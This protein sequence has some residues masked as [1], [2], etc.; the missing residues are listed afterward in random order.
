MP[1]DQGKKM[2][3]DQG[4]KMPMD[5]G[6]KM[7]VDQ[8]KKMSMDQGKKMPVDQGKKMP[9]EHGKKTQQ[10]LQIEKIRSQDKE[11]TIVE[12]LEKLDELNRLTFPGQYDEAVSEF[13]KRWQKLV[14]EYGYQHMMTVEFFKTDHPYPEP[15]FPIK[16]MDDE[17]YMTQHYLSVAAWNRRHKRSPDFHVLEL[18]E[19]K[20]IGAVN[21]S[22]PFDEYPLFQALV[23]I[24]IYTRTLSVLRLINCSLKKEGVV[25]LGKNLPRSSVTHL[26]LDRNPIADEDYS[27]ILKNNTMWNS[28]L[29]FVSLAGNLIGDQG[30]DYLSK[31]LYPRELSQKEINLMNCRYIE[32]IKEL[33]D[34]VNEELHLP[35]VE[36]PN[37]EVD[38]FEEDEEE[39][40]QNLFDEETPKNDIDPIR[41]RVLQQTCDEFLEMDPHPLIA[42]VTICNKKLIGGGNSTLKVLNISYNKIRERGF[43]C[44]LKALREQYVAASGRYPSEKEFN[45]KIIE[46]MGNPCPE[47]YYVFQKIDYYLKQ[48]NKTADHK[49]SSEPCTCIPLLKSS[50]DPDTLLLYDEMVEH[51]K[52]TE[53]E[54]DVNEE[55]IAEFECCNEFTEIDYESS[56][57]KETEESDLDEETYQVSE[58]STDKE[59]LSDECNDSS[60]STEETEEKKQNIKIIE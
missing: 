51:F 58:T 24:C 15:V 3:V 7:P 22:G 10:K 11:F 41:M 19:E 46:Y 14:E 20:I 6:K 43:V 8:G 40:F 38:V 13:V 57:D 34:I 35:V 36:I 48:S 18:R 30:L 50:I 17:H 29:I 4:K 25:M 47:D 56:L 5:Q 1:V 16:I 42:N 23:D 45:L 27:P 2:P 32:R 54:S 28:D 55:T 49:L 60:I 37:Q 21:I 39:G 9:V 33:E 31:S 53:E 59:E 52:P 26:Y 12:Q 44:L